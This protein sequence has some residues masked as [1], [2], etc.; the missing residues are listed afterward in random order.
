MN[1]L[2]PI[3]LGLSILA[4][5]ATNAAQAPVQFRTSTDVVRVYATVQDKDS[6]LV[7][8]LAKEDFVLTDNGK[9]QPIT[10]FSN[11]VAPVSVVIMLDRS[12]SMFQ[13]H[14]RVRDA[15]LQF[16][17]RLLPDDKARIGSFGDYYGNR[18]VIQPSDF[19]SSQVEL[20]DVLR[21]PIKVGQGSPVWIS[22]DQSIAALSGQDGRRVVLIF[23]D[24]YDSPPVKSLMP[25]K[26]KDLETRVRQT[27]TMVYAIGFATTEMR[28]DGS[29]RVEKPHE[30]LRTLADDS[31]GG[32]F[33]ANDDTDLTAMFARVA[34]ELH[35]QYFIGFEPT[36]NDGKIHTI[37][38]QVK[39]PGLT[40]RA[41]Q[42][43]V[44]A[45][46]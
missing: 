33:E 13:H 15:A 8:D 26:L 44:A 40:V 29:K 39:R 3:A 1:R 42:T 21:A 2:V 10:L 34:E 19:S 24:G 45:S 20:M 46:K 30:G 16:I 11:E 14:S 6:R 18:V 43:Y 36:V 23:S 5:T 37:K 41:R 7:L 25:V 9:V 27:N 38:L 17:S 28:S 31:G 12:G 22:I 4:W 32:Y 35:R